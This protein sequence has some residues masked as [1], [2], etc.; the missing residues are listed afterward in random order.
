MQTAARMGG[1]PS[2]L[3]A[4][5]SR[6]AASQPPAPP[7]AG[8]PS[9]RAPQTARRALSGLSAPDAPPFTKLSTPVYSLSSAAADGSSHTLNVITYASPIAL[10]PVRKYALGLYIETLTYANVKAT[11]RCVL[12]VRRVLHT[13]DC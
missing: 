7:R 13:L 6:A 10:R 3:D 9:Q 1:C 12:Q 11:G 8:A 4:H 5:S 2:T